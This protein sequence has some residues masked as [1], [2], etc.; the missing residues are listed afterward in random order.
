MGGSPVVLCLAGKQWLGSNGCNFRAGNYDWDKLGSNCWEAMAGK[1]W[2]GSNGLE[3]MAATFAL[4]INWLG[5]ARK[6]WLGSNGWEAMGGK[7]WLGSNGC[8]FLAGN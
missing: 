4:G 1:Q 6:Q 7:Q 2:V 5:Q 3:A 8:N